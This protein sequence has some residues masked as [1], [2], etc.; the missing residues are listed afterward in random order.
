[1]NLLNRLSFVIDRKPHP[2]KQR[3]GFLLKYV[4][5]LK[6]KDRRFI[7][8]AAYPSADYLS[9]FGAAAFAAAC[10]AAAAC[11]TVARVAADAAAGFG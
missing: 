5:L 1:M 7:A 11:V 6:V 2:A 10:A 4:T 9:A 3:W 8:P